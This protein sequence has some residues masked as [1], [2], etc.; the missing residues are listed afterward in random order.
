MDDKQ[1]SELSE[2][3]D[4]IIKLLASSLVQGKNLTQQ[5]LVLSAIGLERKEIA[6]I[7]DKDADLISATLY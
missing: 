4:T 5:A 2:K 3:I 1:F 6:V 7:L